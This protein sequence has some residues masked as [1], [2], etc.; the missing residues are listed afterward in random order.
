MPFHELERFEKLN[1]VQVNVFILEKKDL[2]PLRVS[3]FP[4]DLI[5]NLLLL[6]EGGSHH[7]LITDLKHFVNFLKNKQSRSRDEISQKLFSY[8]YFNR[9]FRKAQAQ[10]LRKRGRGDRFTR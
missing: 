10:L 4:S 7:V 6:S 8:L 3:K 1:K 5:M 2:L 9:E